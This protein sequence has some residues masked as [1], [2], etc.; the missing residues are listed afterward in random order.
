MK[1]CQQRISALFQIV[2]IFRFC[3]KGGKPLFAGVKHLLSDLAAAGSQLSAGL[4]HTVRQLAVGL[5]L[6]AD[7]L[8]VPHLPRFGLGGGLHFF[9]LRGDLLV[10]GLDDGGTALFAIPL[11]GLHEFCRALVFFNHLLHLKS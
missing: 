8:I 11:D 1:Q 6:Q 4:H 5:F 10:D 2:G 7:F 9:Q 3:G